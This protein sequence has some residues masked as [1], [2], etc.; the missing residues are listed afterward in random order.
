MIRMLYGKKGSGK[1]KKIVDMANESIANA[2]GNS[3]FIDDDSR[4]MYDLKRDIRFV[5]T[6]EYNIKTADALYGLICGMLAQNYD[7]DNIYIDGV[8][9][10]VADGIANM[11][12]FFADLDKL[13]E[14]AKVDIT[15]IVSADADQMPEFL[16]KYENLI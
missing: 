10:I 16:K 8:N 7:I 15:M 11:E 6:N 1:S 12:K 5:N 13:V 3:V 2:K 9:N 4:L 14:Q